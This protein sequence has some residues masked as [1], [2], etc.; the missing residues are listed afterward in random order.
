VPVPF[1][2]PL[3]RALPRP[4]GSNARL[5]LLASSAWQGVAL[6]F[7]APSGSATGC[8]CGPRHNAHRR[9]PIPRTLNRKRTIDRRVRDVRQSLL[10]RARRMSKG[11]PECS[12][13]VLPAARPASS[14]ARRMS[15]R[16]RPVAGQLP[17]LWDEEPDGYCRGTRGYT[18]GAGGYC[19]GT[20]RGTDGYC[21]GARG[22][23]RGAG[24]V[25]DWEVAMQWCG[26]RPAMR[27]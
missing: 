15:N 24:G 5:G 13:G 7:G 19:R 10:S 16:S 27:S 11:Y 4:H 14:R 25:G 3:S 8:S 17:T 2:Q 26:G 12:L 9:Q 6:I 23:T 22:Y 21:R 18:R 20:H 1:L